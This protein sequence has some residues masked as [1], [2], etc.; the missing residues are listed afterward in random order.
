ME[1]R[2]VWSMASPLRLCVRVYTK[3][4]R[5]SAFNSFPCLGREGFLSRRHQQPSADHVVHEML[6]KTW[7]V[8]SYPVNCWRNM[9]RWHSNNDFQL[10]HRHWLCKALVPASV[11][12]LIIFLCRN[13]RKSEFSCL[14]QPSRGSGEE[15]RE[16]ARHLH[17]SKAATQFPLDKTNTC[18]I[19][20]VRGWMCKAVG[21]CI[22][23]YVG[24]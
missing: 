17:G 2:C 10:N 19:Q 5:F 16:S 22:R 4:R 3:Q 6:H 18:A 15:L 11:L 9:N 21:K 1:I 12:D 8:M 24:G 23:M 7:Y 14:D 13:E 20:I